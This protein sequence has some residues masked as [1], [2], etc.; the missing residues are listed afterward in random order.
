MSSTVTALDAAHGSPLWQTQVPLVKDSSGMLRFETVKVV[1]NILVAEIQ[2]G[3][4]FMPGNG[5]I[6]KVLLEEWVL[7][8]RLSLFASSSLN[9]KPCL[10]YQEDFRL[11]SKR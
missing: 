7:F 5:E 11:T 1:G 6:L 3:Q 2:G 9:D 4:P 10:R 8:F